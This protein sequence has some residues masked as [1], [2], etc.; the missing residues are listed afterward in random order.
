M[1]EGTVW[2]V[3]RRSGYDRLR[4]RTRRLVVVSHD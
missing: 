4:W 1:I 2:P 3:P